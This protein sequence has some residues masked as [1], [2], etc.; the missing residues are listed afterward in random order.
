MLP[1]NRAGGIG[2]VQQLQHILYWRYTPQAN[3][4]LWSHNS[5]KQTKNC[6]VVQGS[7]QVWLNL[8]ALG[9]CGL[10]TTVLLWTELFIV[11]LVKECR[12]WKV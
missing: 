6:Q 11:L 1:R 3:K 2:R 12:G 5:C 10:A 8:Q 7:E 4:L 9:P